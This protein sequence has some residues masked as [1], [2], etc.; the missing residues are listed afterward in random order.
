M[1][2]AFCAFFVFC[3]SQE[4]LTY[5]MKFLKR[6]L[7]QI[8]QLM[9]SVPSGIVAL[10]VASVV[11]MNLLANKSIVFGSEWLALDCGILVS[12]VAFLCMDVITKRFGPKAATQISIFAIAINLFLCLMFFVA[13][14]IPGVWSQSSADQ[15]VQEEINNA[16]NATFGSTWFVILGSNIAFVLSSIVNNFCNWGI[17]KLFKKNPSGKVAFYTRMLVAAAIA[18]FCDNFVFALIVSHTFFGWTLLQCLVCAL[19]GMVAELIFEAVFSPLGWKICKKW[20]AEEIGK[21][22]LDKQNIGD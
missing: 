11:A 9:R 21:Q 1:M 17:G 5:C 13:S 2:G 19:I 6:E 15:I 10:F 16:I 20:Q 22:Y 14:I 8:K 4:R 12:W 7:K 18:Q 3:G